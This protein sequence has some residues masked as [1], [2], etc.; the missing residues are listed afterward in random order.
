M[1]YSVNPDTRSQL[2]QKLLLQ[3]LDEVDDLVVYMH[4]LEDGVELSMA[5]YTDGIADETVNRPSISSSRR[6]SNIDSLA[7]SISHT[8]SRDQGYTSSQLLVT[9]MST[10]TLTDI[11]A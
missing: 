8:E 7:P 10:R 9:P 5:P 1:V 4:E 2:R 11:P 3:K 6:G